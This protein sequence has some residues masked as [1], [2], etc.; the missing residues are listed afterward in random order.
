VFGN[1]LKSYSVAFEPETHPVWAQVKD[2]L[3]VPAPGAPGASDV[4]ADGAAPVAKVGG[5]TS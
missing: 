2:K 5:A 3:A 1:F 4:A